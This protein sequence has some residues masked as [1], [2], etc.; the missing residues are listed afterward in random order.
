MIPT[1]LIGDYIM[2]NK[3]VYSPAASGIEEKLFPVEGIQRG[4]V[5]VF[6]YPLEP[7]KDYI[8]RVIGL[9]GETIEVRNWDL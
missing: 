2:V 8:K 6:K 5:I 7:E 9:P 3:Y 4:D 1:L